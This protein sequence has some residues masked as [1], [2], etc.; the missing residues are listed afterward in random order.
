MQSDAGSLVQ[1]LSPGDVHPPRVRSSGDGQLPVH[2]DVRAGQCPPALSPS[3]L[4]LT[5]V[6]VGDVN[7][8]GKPDLVVAN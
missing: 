1:N 7:G 3:A 2:L 5:S 4:A 6:A 8:D